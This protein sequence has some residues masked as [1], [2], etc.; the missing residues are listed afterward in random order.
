V[1]GA[2]FKQEAAFLQKAK[3]TLMIFRRRPEK[4]KRGEELPLMHQRTYDVLFDWV[5]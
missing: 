2:Y 3:K 4:G 5:D 1:S